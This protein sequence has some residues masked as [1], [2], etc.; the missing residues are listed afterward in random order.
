MNFFARLNMRNVLVICVCLIACG[1]FVFRHSDVTIQP[2]INSPCVSSCIIES[3]SIA[4]ILSYVSTP[5]V[6]VLFD[7]DNTLACPEGELGSD[8]WFTYL[9][10]ENHNAGM[11]DSNALESALKIY[12][13]AHNFINLVPAEKNTLEILDQLRKLNIPTA[14]FT[15]RSLPIVERTIEQ[16]A[17]AGIQLNPPANFGKE[18][19]FTVNEKPALFKNNIIFCNN[20]DKGKTLTN[21]FKEFN[22]HPELVLFVDDKVSHLL[23]V[24]SECLAHNIRFVGVRY[25]YLDDR[26]KNFN[27]QH[28]QQE[29]LKLFAEHGMPE[30]TA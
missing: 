3:K 22:Y 24:Q 5:N 12:F 16:L 9:M 8:Q 28:A 7:I 27:P 25:G 30:P 20:N 14:A 29:L 17:H 21:L 19:S 15:T 26:V 23:T 2:S 13:H 6:I 18:L 10:T 4:D 11:N 1:Y